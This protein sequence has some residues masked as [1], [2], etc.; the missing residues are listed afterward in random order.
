MRSGSRTGSRAV[1]RSRPTTG[2]SCTCRK[3]TA[4]WWCFSAE[5]R[6][7]NA[8]NR[9]G[10][11]EPTTKRAVAEPAAA[12]DRGGVSRYPGVHLHLPPRQVSVGVRP[13]V[14]SKGRI[15]H[16]QQ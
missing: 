14:L 2:S 4:R 11:I 12:P 8:S 13:F 15:V 3:E 1:M 7:G 6:E 10:E 16:E 9:G 5:S